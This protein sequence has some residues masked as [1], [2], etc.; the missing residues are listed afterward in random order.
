MIT[1]ADIQRM[2]AHHCLDL[3]MV[4]ASLAEDETNKRRSDPRLVAAWTS[5]AT[6]YA[7]LATAKAACLNVPPSK[8]T[9]AFRRPT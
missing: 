4:H 5:M 6:M 3:A 1:L 9:V 2:D 7:S 8:E